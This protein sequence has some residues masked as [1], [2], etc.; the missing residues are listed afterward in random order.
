L[1]EKLDY[2]DERLG[3]HA[4]ELLELVRK[5]VG[6]DEGDEEDDEGWEDEGDGDDDDEED[7]DEE[8]A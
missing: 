2:E 4:T 5:E 8:M 7:G 6:D 3:E 1:F